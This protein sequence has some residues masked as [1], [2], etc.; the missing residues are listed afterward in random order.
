[1]PAGVAHGYQT[2]VDGS[3]LT[4]L[5]SAAYHPESARSLSWADATVAI[6]WPLPVT[7]ISDRDREA[8]PWPPS[9]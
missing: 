1:M 7:V 3:D 8:P 9:R 2:L 5:I 6:D 4:Y